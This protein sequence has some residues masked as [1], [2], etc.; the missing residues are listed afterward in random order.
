MK[1]IIQGVIDR[2]LHQDKQTL[3]WFVLYDGIKPLIRCSV[4]ELAFLDNKQNISSICSGVYI[5]EKRW[6]EKFGNH[7]ILLDVDGREYILIHKGNYFKDTRGCL[8]FGNN[9]TDFNGD[10]YLDVTISSRTMKKLYDLAPDKWKL[11]I[12]EI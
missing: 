8:L 4:L 6:S 12:N 3:G 10:G 7:F 9:F 2:I 11:T 5:V 1:N